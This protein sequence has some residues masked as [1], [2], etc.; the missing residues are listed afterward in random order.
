MTQFVLVHGA[1]RGS[2][3][4][5]RVRPLLQVYGHEVFTPTLTGL[6]E[7]SHLLSPAIDLETHIADVVNLVRWEA[8][9]TSCY[10]AIRMPDAS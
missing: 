2:W 4:W 9:T 7:R 3:L 5:Q 10:V 6:S 1:W 8:S